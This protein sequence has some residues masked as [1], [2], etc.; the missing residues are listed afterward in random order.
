MSE[1]IATQKKQLRKECKRHR[2]D[3]DPLAREQANLKICQFLEEWE[4]FRISET[5]LTYMP[6][7]SEVDLRPLV[8]GYSSKRWAIPRILPKGQMIFQ[9]YDP[10]ALVL[11]PYGMWEPHPDCLIMTPEEIQLTL[12]PGLAFDHQGWRLGY[13]GGFYD[14]FLSNFAGKF[15]GITYE[16]LVLDHIPHN[17]YD[18]PMQFLVT[19]KRLANFN[20]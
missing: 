19:E 9:L 2:D 17:T 13:G 10:S 12:V 8:A 20:R 7:H 5:I 18:I 3:I 14:R 16:K 6:M 1:N 4:K 11:H 15:V